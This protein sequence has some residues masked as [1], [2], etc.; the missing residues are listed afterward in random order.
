MAIRTQSEN[1]TTHLRL[2]FIIRCAELIKPLLI[3]NI[4]LNCARTSLIRVYLRKYLPD[5]NLLEVATCTGDKG[6]IYFCLYSEVKYCIIT[7]L[8]GTWLARIPEM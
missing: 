2:S 6:D 7:L 5:D 1:Y 3:D 8:H 4:V